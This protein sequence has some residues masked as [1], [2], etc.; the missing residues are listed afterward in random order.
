[1]TGQ[2]LAAALSKQGQPD[3]SS[4]QYNTAKKPISEV[5]YSLKTEK[6]NHEVRRVRARRERDDLKCG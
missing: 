3:L 2:F 4:R 6:F 5:V 1:V